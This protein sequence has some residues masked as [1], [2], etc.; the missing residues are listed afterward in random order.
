MAKNTKNKSKSNG[1]KLAV[2]TRG[3]N[4]LTM[5]VKETLYGALKS[6]YERLDKLMNYCSPDEKAKILWRFAKYLSYGKD[7]ISIEL[8]QILWEQLEPHYKKL[9]F[10]IPHLS[11]KEKITVLRGLLSEFTSEQRKTIVKS[12][13]SQNIKF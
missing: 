9:R 10:Y 5:E 6:D 13:K 4:K 2:R 8:K 1:K 11:P 3:Q 12:I 7:D